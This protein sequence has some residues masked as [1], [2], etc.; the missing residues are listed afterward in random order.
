MAFA[1]RKKK[2]PCPYSDQV[3]DSS[4]VTLINRTDDTLFYGIGTSWFEDTLLPGNSRILKYGK[5]NVTYD[6]DCNQN[7]ESW[8]THTMHTNWGEWAFAIDHCNKMTAFEYTDE[9]KGRIELYD[10]SEK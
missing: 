10:V 1:C 2:E 7:K 4:Q 8:S 5:V 9:S 6:E 3:C